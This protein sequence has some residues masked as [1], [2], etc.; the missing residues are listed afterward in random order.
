MANPEKLPKKMTVEEYLQ[1]EEK[2]PIRHEYLNGQIVAM[3]GGTKAHSAI[4]TNILTSLRNQLKGGPCKVYAGSLKVRVAATNSFYYPDVLVDCGDFIKSDVA[5]ETPV[6]IFEVLSRSTAGTDRREKLFAY[7]QLQ[8]LSTYVL[9]GQNTKSV[10]VYRRA[11]E[12]SWTVEK[13]GVQDRFDVVVGKNKKVSLSVEEIYE[14][15]D[16]DPPLNLS[17]HENVEVYTY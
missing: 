10:D 14:D 3:T 12:D 6:L 11:D 9:V 5:T 2:S 8:S 13:L 7:Q 16:V 1:F 15:L 17:V 4:I